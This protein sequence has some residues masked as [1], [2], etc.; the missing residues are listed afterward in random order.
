VVTARNRA[1]TAKAVSD[2]RELVLPVV[3]GLATPVKPRVPALP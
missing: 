2:A 3:P 1:G